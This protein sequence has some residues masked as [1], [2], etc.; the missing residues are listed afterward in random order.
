M[1]VTM[2]TVINITGT[3]TM[4][5]LFFLCYVWLG[6]FTAQIIKTYYSEFLLRTLK[7]L[8]HETRPNTWLHMN[9]MIKISIVHRK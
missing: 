6:Y 8:V 3:M 2:E 9:I 1:M 7:Y 4:F 5:T